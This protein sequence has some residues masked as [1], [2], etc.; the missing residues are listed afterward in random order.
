MGHVS[1]I[2]MS[3]YY[4]TCVAFVCIVVK[5]FS[6]MSNNAVTIV[7]R[8]YRAERGASGTLIASC[9]LSPCLQ[10]LVLCT[11]RDAPH[12]IGGRTVHLGKRRRSLTTICDRFVYGPDHKHKQ[13]CLQ[14]LQQIRLPSSQPAQRTQNIVPAYP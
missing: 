9:K 3:K 1:L 2:L 13:N 8:N 7:D 14:N 10:V 6:I 4:S 12:R 11:V 5:I